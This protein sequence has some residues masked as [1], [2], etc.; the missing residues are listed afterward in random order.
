[1]SM[2]EVKEAI[3]SFSPNELEELGRWLEMQKEMRANRWDE[4]IE[5]D[6]EAGKLNDLAAGVRADIAAGRTRPL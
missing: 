6:I 4:Q 1:M 3:S 2:Q 5:R